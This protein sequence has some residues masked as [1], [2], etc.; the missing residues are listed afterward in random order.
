MNEI[1][2]RDYFASTADLSW[3]RGEFGE[4]MPLEFIADKVGINP[5]PSPITTRQLARFLTRVEI[6]WRWQYADL[7]LKGRD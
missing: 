2:R 7:M 3:M 6:L 1:S 4:L 5:P